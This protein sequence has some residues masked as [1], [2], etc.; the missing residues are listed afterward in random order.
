MPNFF[1]SA[2]DIIFLEEILKM[3]DAKLLEVNFKVQEALNNS[4]NPDDLDLFSK[5][6]YIIGMGFSACQRHISSTL[7][8][9][10]IERSTALEVGPTHSGKP[11]VTIINAAANYWKHSD[12]WSAISFTK[13]PESEMVRINVRDSE[14]LNKQQKETILTIEAV[15]PW[16]DYTCANILA[17]LTKTN[18]LKLSELIPI[19]DE[20]RNEL[21]NKYGHIKAMLH[22]K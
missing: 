5:G 21:V 18:E 7:G 22:F 3:L 10:E 15:A 16:S 13:I 20:W 11:I 6:E 8:L 17:S 19:L 9:I 4:L 1:D 2:T 12:D 14:F